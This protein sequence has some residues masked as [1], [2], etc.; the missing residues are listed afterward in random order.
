MRIKIFKVL[1]AAMTISACMG[2]TVC[3][4]PKQM[5][6]GVTFD[7]QY[8]A[9]ANPDVVAALGSDEATLYKHYA[10]YGKAEGR[11]PVA[12]QLPANI[13]QPTQEVIAWASD[14]GDKTV[15]I[16]GKSGK[17][18]TY[19]LPTL[20][21]RWYAYGLYNGE[22]N[23][24]T[25]WEIYNWGYANEVKHAGLMNEAVMME[26]VG[27][28]A[29]GN[30]TRLDDIINISDPRFNTP[31]VREYFYEQLNNAVTKASKY[32]VPAGDF[33]IVTVDGSCVDEM[34]Y[35]YHI[36]DSNW[37]YFDIDVAGRY[38]YGDGNGGMTPEYFDNIDVRFDKDY[39]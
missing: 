13:E 20:K 17:V 22:T 16:T 9:Q 6:D 10:L 39:E 29:T 38:A 30:V 4:A 2:T 24:G 18:Y 12:V 28:M 31:W 26:I 32:G 7:P 14:P 11:Q 25:N 37:G 27:A 1:A 36:Y 5:A 19:S 23:D 15:S 34:S 3:A 8:Y 35:T 21:G 33:R